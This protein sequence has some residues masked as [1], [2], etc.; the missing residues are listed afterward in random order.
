MIG[1][2][3]RVY[4]FNDYTNS[5]ESYYLGLNDTLPYVTNDTLKVK[6][7]RGSSSST[8]LW[9]HRKFMEAW[10]T[11]RT[12]WGKGIYVPFAFKRIWEGGHSYQS[13]HYA[14][15][16]IDCGQNLNETEREKLRNLA[17]SLG[18]FEYV[19]PK[20]DAS[21]WVHIDK[22]LKPP[23][24]ETGYITLRNG[25]KNTCVFVLQDALNA[26]GYTGGGLDGIFGSGT[27]NSVRRFQRDQGLTV[28]G[29][30]GC[31]A[32]RRLTS[33]AKGIRKTNT[34]VNP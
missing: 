16:A 32:W 27:E 25:S 13:Q 22:R 26:L 29:I 3:I 7:F 24:C 10:N 4:V 17:K 34:V 5:F 6:E 2:S 23:A 28:D 1:M 12:A 8:V 11:L 9:T 14:G 30:V 33:L 21:T 31:N 15:V 19:E 18:V 20:S